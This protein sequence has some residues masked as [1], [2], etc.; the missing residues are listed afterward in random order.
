M[1]GCKKVFKVMK[2]TNSFN[3]VNIVLNVLKIKKK[4]IPVFIVNSKQTQLNIQRINFC[5][6]NLGQIFSY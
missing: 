1:I 6:D 4:D 5:N 2:K 3:E